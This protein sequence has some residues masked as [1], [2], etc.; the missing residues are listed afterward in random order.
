MNRIQ[1]RRSFLASTGLGIASLP[2]L[3]SEASAACRAEGPRRFLMIIFPNGAPSGS[4]FPKGS[5]PDFEMGS[6]T[7][8]FEAL[9]GHMIAFDGAV[10]QASVDQGGG[11]HV[12]FPSLTT[13]VRP[14]KT[15]EVG[16]T[17][18]GNAI[19]ID[20]AIADGIAQK[21]KTARRSLYLGA[22][23]ND[24]S[25]AAITSYAG[26][27]KA[28]T[29][30]ENPYTLFEALFAG[31]VNTANTADAQAEIARLRLARKSVFDHVAGDL[32]RWKAR[33]GT[34]DRDKI[35]F[36]VTSLRELE[37]QLTVTLA[38]VNACGA[39][40][41]LVQGI[42]HKDRAGI[43]KILPAQ[44]DIAVGALAADV[45]RVVNLT[46]GD[47][48]ADMITFPFL[49]SA[50]V[51]TGMRGSP[52]GGGDDR[53]WHAHSHRG[54]AEH[55]RILTWL[56]EKIA[57]ALKK[58]DA[59]KEGERSLLDNTAVLLISSQETGGGHGTSRIPAILFGS[60]GGAWK[61]GRAL[62]MG[63]KPLNGLYVAIAQAMGLPMTQFGSY[64][65]NWTLT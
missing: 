51:G 29:P 64:A 41:V 52:A 13:G 45:T 60:C 32:D 43:D 21:V 40:P 12:C 48:W 49:G 42:N 37:R 33:L 23:N 44:L 61:T 47:S 63:G 54:G 27:Q 7:R 11:G 14:W 8:P 35:D 26:P 46:I 31:A 39:K 59:L 30:E 50:H 19:S 1:S 58:M 56:F 38:D 22:L 24:G 28:V 36:H 10:C 25:T 17:A 34:E 62:H 53:A 16:H 15:T 55:V 57:G 6:V 2:L 20:Q 9:K 4:F 5:G 3:R 18:I 65:G